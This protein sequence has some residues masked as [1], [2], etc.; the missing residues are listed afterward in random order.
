MR[1]ERGEKK[2]TY[3]KKRGIQNGIKNEVR[4]ERGEKKRRREKKRGHE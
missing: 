2:E 4:N 1:N 3:E